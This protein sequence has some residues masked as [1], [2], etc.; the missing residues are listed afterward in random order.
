MDKQKIIL[1]CA[2][3]RSGS[4]TLQRII[5]TISNSNIT[6][7]NNGAIINLLEFYNNIKKIKYIPKDRSGNF[8]TYK[9]CEENKIKPCWYNCYDMSTVKKSIQKLIIDILDNNQNNRVIGYKEIR[10]FNKL[11]TLNTFLE[12]FPKT[13]IICHYRE[14]LDLQCKSGWWDESSRE[15]LSIYNKQLIEY[16][17]KNNNCYLF[18]F[19]KIFNLE[20]IKKLF[21]FLEEDLDEIK[22]TYIIN[23]K[24]E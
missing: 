5:N 20:E 12:L 16:S 1:I 15:H 18:T 7:E 4:T 10:Y 14:D 23:N 11:D 6:G 9:E 17:N 3:G 19:E 22:Y 8:L 24:L 21:E 13:K 2:T